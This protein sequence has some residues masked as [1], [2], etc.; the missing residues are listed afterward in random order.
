VQNEVAHTTYTVAGV[1]ALQSTAYRTMDGNYRE[2][3][4][5]IIGGEETGVNQGIPWQ[6]TAGKAEIL[7]TGDDRAMTMRSA[8]L[9]PDGRW[10]QYY[11][12]VELRGTE[13]TAGK[14]CYKLRA[15]PFEGLPQ[16]LYYDVR[17]GL[18]V[19]EIV[20]TTGGKDIDT[21]ADDYMVV[22][23]VRV[24]RLFS[25]HFGLVT[26]RVVV[27]DMKFNQQIQALVFALPPEIDRLKQKRQAFQ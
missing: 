24:P 18:Q 20:T 1:T 15:T 7:D 12:T 13:N 16:T 22:D 14:P 19:R 21:I 26:L 23:G 3:T 25:V 17:T 27:D 11:K 9:L 10:R 2:I 8:V 5:G 4:T 6:K